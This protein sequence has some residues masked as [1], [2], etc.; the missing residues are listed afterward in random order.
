ME[1]K[2]VSAVIMVKDIPAS[3]HFYE[4]ILGQK[5]LMDHGLNVGYEGGFAIWQKDFALKV[6]FN[7]PVPEVTAGGSHA[8]EI[9]FETENL[10]EVRRKL[11]AAGV[12][13]VHDL[14]EQPWGQRVLR[15]YDP[16]QTIIEI[17]E[18]MSA[19][20]L[21]L[22]HSG[23]SAEEITKRTSMPLEIVQQ[24]AAALD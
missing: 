24:I 3:R 7:R 12:E 9:Y 20:I 19:V 21:R 5:V 15:V 14:I 4:D 6:I 10:E 1:I 8:M 23:L 17:G 16:D 2:F 13:F 18:P 11:T 22:L